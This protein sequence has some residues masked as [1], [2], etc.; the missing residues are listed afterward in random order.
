MRLILFLLLIAGLSSCVNTKKF[1][2]VW[3]PKNQHIYQKVNASVGAPEPT[4]SVVEWNLTKGAKAR[5]TAPTAPSDVVTIKFVQNMTERRQRD[6]AWVSTT[7]DPASNGCYVPNLSAALKDNSPII[8]TPKFRYW[9]IR[10]VF[11][12][13]SIPIKFRPATGDIKSAASASFNVGFTYAFK[14]THNTYKRV[15]WQDGGSSA[16]LAHRQTKMTYAAGPFLGPTV[17][18]LKAGNTNGVVTKD[19]S[20]VGATYGIIGI[21]GYNELNAGLAIGCDNVFHT[22]KGSWIYNKKL[23]L[24]VV[25][26]IDIIK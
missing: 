16:F 17:V 5:V 6:S 19:R 11:Q 20:V 21:V 15:L 9:D 22:E 8:A 2:I 3:I 4:D 1:G 7:N 13:L 25:I 18:D 26:A 10:P 12:T 14:F 24:G 23:W